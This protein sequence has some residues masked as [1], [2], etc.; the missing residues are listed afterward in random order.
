MQRRGVVQVAAAAV[1]A[2]ALLSGCG[3]GAL[4]AP[5][6]SLDAA[7]RTLQA[8]PA[9]ARMA[10]GWPLPQ[11]LQHASQSVEY[12]MSGFPE[13]RSALFRGT[14]G[15]L[16]FAWFDSRGQMSHG[17]TEP[18]PGAPPLVADL[19][20]PQAQARLVQALLRF[21]SH[22]GP[23][24]PHFAY[25]ALDKAAYLRAHLMHLNDHWQHY[26]AA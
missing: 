15:P 12:S 22:S 8:L 2:P 25:G 21:D 17:L 3:S 9:T 11:V 14:A 16:A 1:A 13:P 10:A 5:F 18:I 7:L 4:A 6:A 23:L 20:L 26:R 24:Q 19:A